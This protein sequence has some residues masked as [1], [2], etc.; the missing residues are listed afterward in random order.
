MVQMHTRAHKRP[1]EIWILNE[2]VGRRSRRGREDGKKAAR[3]RWQKEGFYLIFLWRTDDR[4]AVTESGGRWSLQSRTRAG[5]TVRHH[6]GL[7]S[8]TLTQAGKG[9]DWNRRVQDGDVWECAAFTLTTLA[10]SLRF[11][12]DAWKVSHGY[13]AACKLCHLISQILPLSWNVRERF[14]QYLNRSLFC[15]AFSGTP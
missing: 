5:T 7:W 4:C 6:L 2:V 3:W 10:C 13:Y 8:R 11:S 12:L 15:R 14:R 1:P 9:R